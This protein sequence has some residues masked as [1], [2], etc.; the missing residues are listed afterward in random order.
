M[1]MINTEIRT[2]IVMCIACVTLTSIVFGFL[3]KPQFLY[4][5]GEANETFFEM[6]MREA[7]QTN[8]PQNTSVLQPTQTNE[9]MVTNATSASSAPAGQQ[10]QTAA[11]PP[12]AAPTTA[13][14]Q[15]QTAAAPPAAAPT[16]AGQQNQTAAAPPAAAPTTAG[17]QNQTAPSN[18]LEQLGQ[19]ISKLFGGGK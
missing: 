11:A 4:A 7:T 10:N 9:T 13:G 8:Q 12:A 19:A 15:N 6:T 3:V 17:Q 1:N 5:Q 18:P 14:Q 16:T 2:S